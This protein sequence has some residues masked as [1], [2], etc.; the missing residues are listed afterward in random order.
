MAD[1]KKAL[2]TG[3]AGFI[4][5]HMVDRLLELDYKVVV[6]DDLSTGKIKNLNS[7]AVFHH[8]D[9]TKR[10]MMEIIQ[11]EQPDLVFHMAAQTSVTA[12]TKNP[13]DDTN[14]NVVGTLRVLEASRRVGVE[15]II[16]SCTGGA[17]YGDPD[18][19]PCTDDAPIRPV[20]P[21]GMSK[22][23]AEQYMDFY[24]RQ[25]RLNYTS[26]R[27]GNVY[28]PRQDPH[29]EAGVVAIFSRS[30]LEGQQPSIYGDGTQERDFV[31]VFDVVDANLEAIDRGD[32]LCMNIATGEATSINRIF[33]ILRNI[34][35]YKWEALHAP[36]RAGEVYKIA[37]DWSRAALELDW[38]PKISLEEGLQRTVDHFRESM[39]SSGG[40]PTAG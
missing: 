6:M 36:Q 25:Y 27:Y 23:I 9:I 1:G 17:L 33:D 34:T 13:I 28:G 26:L 4:G 40:V 39:N 5:S 16:Y 32:G 7:G 37:L 20:S 22:W 10:P 11:R 24:Y 12:S 38:A 35:G 14:A 3:G 19:I 30:M 15:K 21:Y 2:V 8:T 31:S 29:G 18:T